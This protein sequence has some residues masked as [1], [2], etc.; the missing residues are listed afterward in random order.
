MGVPRSYIVV[1]K[2]AAVDMSAAV[3]MLP[4]VDMSPT[5]DMSHCAVDRQHFVVDNQ[6]STCQQQG[7]VLDGSMVYSLVL[8]RYMG[9]GLA[10][11]RSRLPCLSPVCRPVAENSR[12]WWGL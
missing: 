7:P 1:D 12:H 10:S 3:D 9:E 4:A 5:V 11:D 2:L 6:D 8:Q